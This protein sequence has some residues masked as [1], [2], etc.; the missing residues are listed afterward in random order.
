MDA[1]DQQLSAAASLTSPRLDVFPVS[2]IPSEMW[3]GGTNGRRVRRSHG[4]WQR[5]LAN[6]TPHGDGG[7][8]YRSVH[9]INQY[10]CGDI[11]AELTFNKVYNKHKLTRKLHNVNSGKFKI[12][13]RKVNRCANSSV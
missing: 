13:T 2:R 10:I 11:L 12:A 5:M 9:T 4:C 3:R 7:S 8:L 6:H 1:G